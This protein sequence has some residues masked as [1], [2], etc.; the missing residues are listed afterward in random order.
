[1]RSVVLLS[2]GL[3]SCAVLAHA[4]AMKDEV[5]ACLG[6]KYGSKHNHWENLA[7]ARVASHYG[8]PFWLLDL[9]GPM[10]ALKSALMKADPRPVPEGHYE[11]ES[12]RQTVVPGRNLIFIAHAAAVAESLGANQVYIGCHAGDHIIYP[13]CRPDFLL[14]AMG[15]VYEGSGRKVI[16]C[17]PFVHHSKKAVVTYGVEKNAPFHLTR[18]CYTN[19]ELACGRCGSCQE[20]LAAFRDNYLAD[21]VEYAS[22]EILPE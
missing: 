2:G 9:C 3:D 8:A 5:V 18:T 1:M 17:V 4:T 22:R 16:L 10:A 21:P 6:F 15:A 19:A 14:Q 7:A 20:R 11:A 13:D 12:M